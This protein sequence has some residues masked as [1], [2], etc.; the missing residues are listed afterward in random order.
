MQVEQALVANA[1]AADIARPGLLAARAESFEEATAALA[2]AAT[3]AGRPISDFTVV[4]GQ[5]PGVF[6][7]ATIDESQRPVLEALKMGGGPFYTFVRPFHLCALEVPNTIREAVRGEPPLLDNSR[8]PRIGVG[9]VAKKSLQPGDRIEAGIGSPEVRGEAVRLSEEPS[10]VPIGLLYEA[11]VRRRV[12]PGQLVRIDD[13]ELPE[14]FARDISLA[15]IQQASSTLTPKRKLESTGH[16]P[17]GETF[18]N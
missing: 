1:F 15:L 17:V 7:V 16:A 9:A 5:A 8:V 2:E 10:H 14:S 18:G 13:V 4:A 12:E 11:T 3:D 6:I